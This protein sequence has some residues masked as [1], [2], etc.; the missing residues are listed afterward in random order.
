MLIFRDVKL[1]IASTVASCLLGIT[2]NKWIRFNK[3]ECVESLIVT[4]LGSS[5][6]GNIIGYLICTYLEK[7]T[8]KWFAGPDKK[9]P[10]LSGVKKLVELFHPNVWWNYQWSCFSSAKNFL[11]VFWMLALTQLADANEI[12]LQDIL[13]I[14]SS[15][16]WVY[17]RALILAFLSMICIKEYYE[18][19]NNKYAFH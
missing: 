14:P 12:F 8:Q 6:A 11:A 10:P 17:T 3:N 2:T 15:H 7:H 9:L 18:F 1:C 4:T 5:V 13:K 16:W 19:L